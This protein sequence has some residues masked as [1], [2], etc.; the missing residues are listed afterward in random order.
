M[1]VIHNFSW[2]CLFLFVRTSYCYIAQAGLEFSTQL[3]LV[4]N[5]QNSCL[6]LHLSAEIMGLISQSLRFSRLYRKLTHGFVK[7]KAPCQFSFIHHTYGA[8][9]RALGSMRKLQFSG[10]DKK[11]RLV[12]KQ[13]EVGE[14]GLLCGILPHQLGGRGERWCLCKGFQRKAT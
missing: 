12:E 3:K 9:H 7:S 1:G 14:Q 13:T 8:V 2:V 4:L 10:E 6:S 11:S 5:S